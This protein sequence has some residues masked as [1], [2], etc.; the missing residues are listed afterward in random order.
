MRLLKWAAVELFLCLIKNS[1][2]YNC[3]VNSNIPL[4]FIATHLKHSLKY[5]DIFHVLVT[6]DINTADMTLARERVTLKYYYTKISEIF[7]SR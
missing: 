5:F 4:R 6:I 2:V 3:N 7:K 1:H